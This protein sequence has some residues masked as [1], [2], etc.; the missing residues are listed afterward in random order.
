MPDNRIQDLFGIDLPIIH[1][2][3]TS[4]TTMDLVVA[5]SEAGGLGAPIRSG[6]P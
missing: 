2:P 3:M 4:P 5:V 1:A 6:V